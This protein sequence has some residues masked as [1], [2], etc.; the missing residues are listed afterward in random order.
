M[1]EYGKHGYGILGY[2]M[3]EVSIREPDG[4]I[5]KYLWKKPLKTR[6]CDRQIKES[7]TYQGKKT[8]RPPRLPKAA[9]IPKKGDGIKFNGD[10]E[11][12]PDLLALEADWDDALLALP[13]WDESLE[14]LNRPLKPMKR[15]E[16]PLELPEG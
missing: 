8:P 2:E 13:S 5:K 7:Y 11:N 15:A 1:K 10:F 16:L 4:S 9:S 14:L 12:D 6:S 3:V